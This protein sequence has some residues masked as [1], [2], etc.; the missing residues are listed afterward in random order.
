MFT[1]YGI[2]F[3]RGGGSFFRKSGSRICYVL[4]LTGVCPFIT[5]NRPHKHIHVTVFADVLV[6]S[7]EFLTTLIV[8]PQIFND[9]VE[10]IDSLVK[11][12]LGL[13]KVGSWLLKLYATDLF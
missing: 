3:F 1:V 4:S 13:S 9:L 6:K 8:F 10:W 12:V 7:R 5:H 11:G 2:G